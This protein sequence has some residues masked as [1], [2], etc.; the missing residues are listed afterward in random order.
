M[1]AILG[2]LQD[3]PDSFLKSGTAK[4]G[5]SEAEIERL[6][7]ARKSAKANKNWAQADSIRDQLKTQG[8]QL[9]DVAGGN[10]IWRRET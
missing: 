7:E 8:I 1:A 3:D 4:D 6:I 5:I 2:L 9:E 10:T